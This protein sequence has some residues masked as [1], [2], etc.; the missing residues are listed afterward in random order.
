MKPPSVLDDP[1]TPG[2]PGD[3]E[4]LLTATPQGPT[5][6]NVTKG[7]NTVLFSIGDRIAVPRRSPTN[8]Y[9]V[10][11]TPLFVNATTDLSSPSARQ[12]IY[13]AGTIVIKVPSQGNGATLTAQDPQF[14]NRKGYFTCVGVNIVNVESPPLN[15]CPSPWN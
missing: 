4:R 8:W 15:I 12:G 6:F 14:Y 1:S 11:F 10:Y 9:R 3:F 13:K 2:T 5:D 7:T